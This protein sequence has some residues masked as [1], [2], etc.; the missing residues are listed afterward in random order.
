MLQRMPGWTVVVLVIVAIVCALGWWQ[1]QKVVRE[2]HT[3]WQSN[4]RLQAQLDEYRAYEWD[5][6]NARRKL[7]V[8]T[9]YPEVLLI[10]LAHEDCDLRVLCAERLAGFG[11]D[12]KYSSELMML[13]M[14][15]HGCICGQLCPYATG[16]A[17]GVLAKIAPDSPEVAQAIAHQ[18]RYDGSWRDN[19][20]YCWALA[21][22]NELYGTETQLR[23]LIAASD[24]PLV[25]IAAGETL[26]KFIPVDSK[27]ATQRITA[28]LREEDPSSSFAPAMMDWLM[29]HAAEAQVAI[30]LLKKFLNDQ[31]NQ[32][33]AQE[34]IDAIKAACSS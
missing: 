19:L 29:A 8:S 23:E 6:I 31:C 25:V 32:V 9:P 20:D 11:L 13:D 34:T 28:M 15:E 4:E 3:V 2:M 26:E 12:E 21:Q 18:F 7:Y 10:G 33:Q 22:F 16:K 27:Y 14:L 5:D 30:P 1:S 24:H 17:A